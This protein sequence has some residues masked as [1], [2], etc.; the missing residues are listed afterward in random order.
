MRLLALC[1][2]HFALFFPPVWSHFTPTYCGFP[3]KRLRPNAHLVASSAGG[4][5]PCGHESG[6]KRGSPPVWSQITVSQVLSTDR[7][8]SRICNPPV[9]SHLD[10]RLVVF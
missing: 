3:E 8:V 10:A 2:S 7:P 9:W 4:G 5:S 6:K 1:K